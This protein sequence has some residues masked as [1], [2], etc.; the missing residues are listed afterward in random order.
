M[1]HGRQIANLFLVFAQCE[2]QPA[3][4]LVE[5]NT[6]GLFIDPIT[7]VLGTRASMLAALRLVDCR[8]PAENLVG[9][10]GFG[11]SHVA[12]V[13]LDDGRYSVAWGCVGIIQACLDACV[14][15]VNERQQFGSFLRDHQLIRRMISDMATNYALRD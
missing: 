7:D 15:Y 12:A 14:Q 11:F 2:G 10:I 3:A 13:A 8:V 4:F 5:Q 9:K 6:P 1:D